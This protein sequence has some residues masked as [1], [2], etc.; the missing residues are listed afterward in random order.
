[1]TRP[2]NKQDQ[3]NYYLDGELRSVYYDVTV[4]ATAPDPNENPPAE[5]PGKE[6]TV[7][8][9]LA[10]PAGMDP[11][12]PETVARTVT[13]DLDDAGNRTGV[14]DSLSGTTSYTLNNLNQYRDN[15]GLDAITNGAEH[16]IASYKNVSYTYIRDE[17]LTRV[18]S[19]NNTYDLAY[20]ALG[21]CVTRTVHTEEDDPLRPTPT[22][23]P[24]PTPYPR[25]G[26]AT[27]YYFYDG[28]RPIVEYTLR[29]LAGYNLYGKGVD[30]ILMRYDPTLTQE[31]K[32][33]YYQQD[34]EGSVTFLTYLPPQGVSPILEYYRYDVFGKPTIY[35]PPPNWSLR[36]ASLYS[37][38]FLF[39]GREYNAMFGFYEYRA[40]AYH[41]D[42]G[43][44]MSEDPKLFDAGDYNLFRYC[45]NDPIDLTD[46]MGLD[47]IPNG[48]GTYHFVLR[49]DVNVHEIIGGYVVNKTDG[50]LRQ[51]AGAAQFLTGTRTADGKLHDAPPASH[52]GW[53]QGAP[54]TKDTPN[55]TMVARRWENG[56]YPNKDIKDYNRE[57]AVKDPSIINHTGIK[58]GWD[59]KNNKPIILDQ[60]KGEPGSLQLRRNYDAKQEDWSVVKATKPYD[61]KP[62]TSEIRRPP[63]IDLPP[64]QDR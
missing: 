36:P 35:G 55:G 10:L 43:R 9:F 16:E 18:T 12:A 19:G 20:D 1:V 23:R 56:V 15:I 4:A 58:M 11:G 6:Q 3:F 48:D 37:S 60:W 59:E 49:S 8:D 41:P 21:R 38:R 30:E 51:C 26:D 22:P 29:G 27:K 5:D 44:F 32:T 62:S 33:F 14:T 39:T 40:R 45:H 63:P 64:P 46:P 13:Y 25:P 53:T 28:E 61:P 24:D 31:P 50:S 2:G 7:D 42:L 34:H 17:H 57:A 52:G 54:V 47:A